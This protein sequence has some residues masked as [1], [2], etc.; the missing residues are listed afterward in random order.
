MQ[1]YHVSFLG[2]RGSYSGMYFQGFKGHP[3]ESPNPD[4]PEG[5]GFRI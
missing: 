5:L 1:E 4:T 3:S 2:L